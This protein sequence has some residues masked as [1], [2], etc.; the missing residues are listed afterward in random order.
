MFLHFL[1]LLWLKEP[2][3]EYRHLG[4]NKTSSGNERRERTA[5][6]VFISFILNTSFLDNIKEP[7][8]SETKPFEGTYNFFTLFYILKESDV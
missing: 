3:G 8:S 2:G 1:F 5:Q 6:P 4:N 7:C